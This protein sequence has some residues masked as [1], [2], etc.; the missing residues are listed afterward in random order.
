MRSREARRILIRT[1]GETCFLGGVIQKKNPLTIHHLVPIRAGG[2]TVL[3]NLALLCRLEHDMFNV[4]EQYKP[5][6]GEEFNDY[7]RYFK[8]TH[9]L[10]ALRQMR[11][12]ALSL[13]TDLGYVVEDRGKILVLKLNKKELL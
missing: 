4:I 10:E 6:R 8:E 7:F 3:A 2:Q 5:K 1:H 9:D 11:E 12:E 13:T